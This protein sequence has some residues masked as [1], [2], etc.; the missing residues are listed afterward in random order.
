MQFHY[1]LLYMMQTCTD[2]LILDF[3]RWPTASCLFTREH[4]LHLTIVRIKMKLLIAYSFLQFSYD[5]LL[6]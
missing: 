2:F 6:R 3:F 1:L 5:I 4:I